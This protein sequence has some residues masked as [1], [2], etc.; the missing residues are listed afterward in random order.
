LGICVGLGWTNPATQ[1]Y[2]E[3]LETLIS[4]ALA[5]MDAT[6]SARQQN[7]VRDLLKS[8]G[9]FVITSVIRPNTTRR[10]YG[11]F[12]IF[13]SRAFGLRLVVLG[14]GGEFIPL[15]GDNSDEV[16]R[17]LGQMILTPTR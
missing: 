4:Q 11:L 16:T 6:D 10:N 13:E 2:G 7:V 12:S 1:D 5:K 17:K 8:Q 15:Q 3:Y 9:K 14:V